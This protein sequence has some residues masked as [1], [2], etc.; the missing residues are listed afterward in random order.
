MAKGSFS[1]FAAHIGASPAYVSKLKKAGR[2]VVVEEGGKKL[3]DFE[4]SERLI[5]NTTDMSRAGN[6]KNGAPG[7]E[8][9]KP[10]AQVA[11]ASKAGEVFR[12]AQAQERIYTAKKAEAVYKKMIGELVERSAI[13]RGIFDVVRAAR[14]AIMPVGQRSA[15]RCIGLGDVRDME[16]IITEEVR[17]AF[18]DFE[19]RLLDKLPKGDRP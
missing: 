8:S 13:E 16:R 6:G 15:P 17:R 12:T 19:Q 2:L 4:L 14:D 9:S 7:T 11:S 1:A 10:A 3:V 18:E 5:K